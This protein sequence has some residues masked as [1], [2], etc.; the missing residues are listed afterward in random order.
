[1]KDANSTPAVAN[2][3]KNKA[4]IQ[5]NFATY[6]LHKT[7]L[8][9]R[10]SSISP[11]EALQVNSIHSST[12]SSSIKSIKQQNDPCTETP[13]LYKSLNRSDGTNT[14]TQFLTLTAEKTSMFSNETPSLEAKQNKENYE[15]YL[16]TGCIEQ[17]KL[18]SSLINQSNLKSLS[19]TNSNADM[20]MT[21]QYDHEYWFQEDTNSRKHSS[22]IELSQMDN[23]FNY[24]RNLLHTPSAYNFSE[25]T[26]INNYGQSESLLSFEKHEMSNAEA[27]SSSS[28]KSVV[29]SQF[30]HDDTLDTDDGS[31]KQGGARGPVKSFKSP[32]INNKIRAKLDYNQN[33]TKQQPKPFKSQQLVPKASELSPCLQKTLKNSFENSSS[34]IS[35][36]SV[37][38][39][40][41]LNN[42]NIDKTVS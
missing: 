27:T 32:P 28:K 21:I 22:I 40:T 1:M 10:F 26:L 36:S 42:H 3:N 5:Q 15:S 29:A 14:K 9:K 23:L 20:H 39:V 17:S 18:Q 12:D 37:T 38:Q 34:K 8:F 31:V 24:D 33:I 30:T 11:I 19:P 41:L 2:L 13:N 6:L 25:E 4:N 16:S 35:D 7:E